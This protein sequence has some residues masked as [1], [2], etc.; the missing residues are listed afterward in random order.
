MEKLRNWSIWVGG[1]LFVGMVAVLLDCTVFSGRGVEAVGQGL[2]WLVVPLVGEG[3]VTDWHVG[4]V[5]FLVLAVV[6]VV[7][8]VA[9]RT[10]REDLF[11]DESSTDRSKKKDYR[12]DR[13]ED[14]QWTW[15]WGLYGN[16]VNL[17]PNCPKCG[18]TI[19]IEKE[20]EEHCVACC[21]ACGYEQRWVQSRYELVQEVRAEINRRVEEGEWEVDRSGEEA[22]R[23]T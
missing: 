20:G 16:V 17:T 19:E 5:Y 8:I 4:L 1:G 15:S 11:S 6:V 12:S 18:T 3:P 13:V 10:R 7:Y 9:G 21:Q 23:P 22:D 14:L 2:Q